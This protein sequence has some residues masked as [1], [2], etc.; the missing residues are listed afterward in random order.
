MIMG[1]HLIWVKSGSAER[2]HF[3]VLWLY[4][5]NEGEAVYSGLS[6]HN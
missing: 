2:N 4:T 1:R 3:T 6:G 5:E